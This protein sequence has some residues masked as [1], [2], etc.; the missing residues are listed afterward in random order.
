MDP[1]LNLNQ[2]PSLTP[3]SG[4]A[5]PAAPASQGAA[6]GSSFGDLLQ[7]ALKEVNDTQS[8][9]EQEARNLMSGN[10]TDMHTAILAVQKADVS[11]QM[12]MAVRS[13]LVDAYRAV[14]QMQM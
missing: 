7:Q 4:T 13:K 11:F 9:S 14:M 10:A 2:L 8:S 12:M 1:L 5:N 6:D 3:L